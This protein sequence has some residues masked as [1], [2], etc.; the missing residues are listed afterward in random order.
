MTTAWRHKVDMTRIA[1]MRDRVK[2][3]FQARHGF[4]LTFLPF[5][6]R[7]T[8]AALQAFPLLNSSDRRHQHHLP[9]RH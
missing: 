9:P 1:K 5:V 6:M 2:G 7:A 4:S 8:T 3:E